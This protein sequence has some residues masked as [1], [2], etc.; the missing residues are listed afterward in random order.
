MLDLPDGKEIYP[1][2]IDVIEGILDCIETNDMTNLKP[3]TMAFMENSYV[4]DRLAYRLMTVSTSKNDVLNTNLTQFTTKFRSFNDS[5][6]GYYEV[7]DLLVGD[8]QWEKLNYLLGK[9]LPSMNSTTDTNVY[10]S[11]IENLTL[12]SGLRL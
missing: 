11:F 1:A 6:G 5:S 10:N 2:Q 7:V 3:H 9:G 8:K 4:Q 12:G